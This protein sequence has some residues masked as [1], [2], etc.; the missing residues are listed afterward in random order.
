MGRKKVLRIPHVA[1]ITCMQ[2]GK[3]SRRTVPLDSSPCY[4][5][6]D[7][8]DFRMCTPVH[9]CCIICAF[10][11]KKCVPALKLEAYQKGLDVR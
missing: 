6:C 1:N 8:C 2:C 7:Q 9:A 11:G 10:T 3:K 5:D 4:F